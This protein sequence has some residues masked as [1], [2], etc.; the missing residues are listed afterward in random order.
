MPKWGQLKGDVCICA[1]TCVCLGCTS[2]RVLQEGDGSVRGGSEVLQRHR[3]SP[4]PARQ[5]WGPFC[6]QENLGNDWTFLAI[7]TGEEVLLAFGG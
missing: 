6:L 5:R 2:S 4:G 3:A 7:T 1:H